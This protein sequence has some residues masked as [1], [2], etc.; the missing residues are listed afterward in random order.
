MSNKLFFQSELIPKEYRE[1]F[2]SQFFK[3]LHGGRNISMGG[4]P[5]A[6]VEKIVDEFKDENEKIKET[7]VKEEAG[8]EQPKITKE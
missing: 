1:W 2:E 8:K 3:A 6:A 7:K 4:S 5:I